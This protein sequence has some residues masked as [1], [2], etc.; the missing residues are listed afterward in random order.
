MS[1]N[2]DFL[3]GKHME[4]V[5]TA[6]MARLKRGL[7]IGLLVIAAIGTLVTVFAIFS[8]G[9]GSRGDI[10]MLGA[11][12]V[13]YLLAISFGALTAVERRG[14][15]WI[16]FLGMALAAF[17]VIAFPLFLWWTEVRSGYGRFPEPTG[18]LIGTAM[19][20]A[21]ALCLGSLVIAP[22]LNLLGRLL[23]IGTVL[24]LLGAGAC[25]AVII[26]AD[27]TT[28]RSLEQAFPISLVLTVAGMLS[29]FAVHR[30]FG[31][32]A[33]DMLGAMRGTIFLK[34]PRCL[35]EQDLAFG[36]SACAGCKL[37][38]SIEVEEPRCPKCG[39]N[40]NQ[41]TRPICPECGENLS[42]E[43]PAARVEITPAEAATPVYAK[44]P[45]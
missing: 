33:R 29:V 9:F 43:A 16:A 12:G 2:R 21:G 39:Y 5:D 27:Y 20:L 17:L 32:K 3:P 41:L 45:Q 37:R 40:L 31:I 10:V 18:Q 24:S 35:K 36:E 30:F 42:G 4:K 26:W 1:E 7:L 38:I 28:S 13:G 11:L 34:C 15:R 6:A 14:I 8:I 44:L 22:R 19:V 25:I 23:Q